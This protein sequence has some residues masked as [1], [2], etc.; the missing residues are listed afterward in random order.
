MIKTAIL[1]FA[2]HLLEKVGGLQSPGSATHVSMF[3]YI[4][5]LKMTSRSFSDFCFELQT[6]GWGQGIAKN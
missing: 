2:L 3:C 6:V 4:L 1:C 5:N